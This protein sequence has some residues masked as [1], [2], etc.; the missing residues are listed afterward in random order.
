MTSILTGIGRSGIIGLSCPNACSW[1]NSQVA[2]N[3][4]TV[5]E[6]D[7]AYLSR[8]KASTNAIDPNAA[9]A[10]TAAV[11]VPRLACLTAGASALVT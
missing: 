1:K 9:N 10:A 2:T 8:S 11:V 6:A 5:D 4:A 7:F 3:V